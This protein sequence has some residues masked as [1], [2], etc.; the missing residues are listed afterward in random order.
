MTKVTIERMD[1]QG[2]GIGYINDKIT[3]IE[4]ALP[5]E[6]VDVELIKE[7]KKYNIAV[8]KNYEKTIKDRIV[9]FCPYYEK[10]GGCK[11]Q[12]LSYENTILY[13]TDKIKNIF[14]HNKIVLPEIIPVI[15]DNPK[16]YR[17]KLSLKII[18]GK[19][20]FYEEKSHD[21]IEIDACAIA[22]KSINSFLSQINK[23]NIKNGLV[24]IRSNYNDE[25][26]IIITTDEK[27]VFDSNKF[28]DLKIVGVVLNNKT[29][30]GNNFFYERMNSCLF[31]VSYDAFFQI[32]P[33]IT[34]KLFGILEENLEESKNVLDLY[35]GVGT[36]GIIASKK[37]DKVC[38]IEI[39][40]N[41]VLDNLENKK[42][43]K[44]ENVQVFLGSAN[45]VLNKIDVDFDSIIIDPPRKGLDNTSLNILLNSNAKKII[46]I[47]CDP[48]TLARD[49][50]K[51]EEKYEIKK[52]YL[53]DM[54]SYTYHVEC[55][56]VLKLK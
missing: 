52:Y 25:L 20:G 27:V 47:S 33:Y 43:N 8:V 28:N 50:N 1:H 10:C 9:P 23:L 48:M 56:C 41:A 40:K 42:L 30:Y 37:S 2:R 13:K 35:S 46:Y 24:T 4:N 14:E 31:K 34:N 16:N 49:I 51:L 55:V 18:N 22:K 5:N 32:N 36:L 45:E 21:L 54:F 19:V 11:L 3:F 38:S 53:L 6:V 15:N 29:I 12:H 39:V 17:N 7:T 26:L 44:C